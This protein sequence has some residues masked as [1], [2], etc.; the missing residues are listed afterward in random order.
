[1]GCGAPSGLGGKILAVW[2]E[3]GGVRYGI[4][5]T[6]TGFGFPDVDPIWRDNTEWPLLD[7]VIDPKTGEVIGFEESGEYAK[8]NIGALNQPGLE[9]CDEA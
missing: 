9:L 7:D 6:A 8:I 3:S 5:G 4:N 2:F 1:M